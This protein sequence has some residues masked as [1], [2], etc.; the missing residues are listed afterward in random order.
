MRGTIFSKQSDIPLLLLH[1]IACNGEVFSDLKSPGLATEF[2]K[3]GF[4]VQIPHLQ[5]SQ[6][7]CDFDSQLLKD[8]PEIWNAACVKSQ[9]A[10]MV[11][12]HSMGGMLALVGQAR[13]IISSPRLLV[14]GTPVVFQRIPFYPN[15]MKKILWICTKLSLPLIPLRILARCVF[16]YF[17]YG[18]QGKPS[19]ELRIFHALIRR[20]AVNVSLQTLAQATS[21]VDSLRFFN[22]FRTHDY[23]QDLKLIKVPVAFVAGEND[24]IAPIASMKPGYDAVSSEE[25]RFEVIKGASPS[26]KT[27]G[28][29]V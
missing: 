27:C 5:T 26:S 13:G 28:R 19:Q 7:G 22:R 25:K 9:T 29:L 8:L 6:E 20:A 23:F 18:N 12:G 17:M 14:L 1:G 21:W 24:R 10:P 15:L 11:L 4:H 2:S 16:I 3:A